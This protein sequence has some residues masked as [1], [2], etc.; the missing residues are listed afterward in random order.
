[1][2]AEFPRQARPA[3]GSENAAG[4]VARQGQRHPPPLLYLPF[5]L[6]FHPL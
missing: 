3:A 5:N 4:K 2:G 1:M 6:H